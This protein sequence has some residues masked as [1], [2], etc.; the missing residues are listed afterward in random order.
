VLAAAVAEACSFFIPFDE[1]AG[2]GTGPVTEAGSPGPGAD[3][4]DGGDD[5]GGLEASC[6]NVDTR[7]DPANCGACGRRCVTGPCDASRCTVEPVLDV[8][9]APLSSLGLVYD[10]GAVDG[11][12]YTRTNGALGRTFLGAATPTEELAPIDAGV[13]PIAVLTAGQLGATGTTTGIDWFRGTN[14][15]D[16]PPAVVVPSTPGL[17][18]LTLEGS[19]VFWGDSAGLSWRDVKAGPRTLLDDAGTPVAFD[20]DSTTLYWTTFNGQIYRMDWRSPG[21]PALVVDAAASGIRALAAGKK[22]VVLAQKSQGLLFFTLDATQQGTLTRKV[23]F[24]DPE[25]VATDSLHVYVLDFGPGGGNKTRL[26]RTDPDG[27]NE[28]LLADGLDPSPALAVASDYVYFAD[29]ARIVRTT[30]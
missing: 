14:F 15:T 5:D 20:S 28:L 2:S 8:G 23:T 19:V 3:G 4:G 27:T 25:A 6:K 18:S 30:K 10:G 26:F 12:Y 17:T 22:S 7:S 21:Y 29:G 11:V 16:T 1:Y 9:S 24:S 13:G